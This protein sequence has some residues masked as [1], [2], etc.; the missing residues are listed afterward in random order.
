MTNG[1]P[2]QYLN[3]MLD[4]VG[5]KIDLDTYDFRYYYAALDGILN[6]EDEFR[7]EMGQWSDGHPF[8]KVRRAY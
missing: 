5:G 8:A 1:G 2:L 4:E 6:G 7:P 3:W